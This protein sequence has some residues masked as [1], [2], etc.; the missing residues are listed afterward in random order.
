MTFP[1]WHRPYLALFEQTLASY[2][3]EVIGDV[4]QNDPALAQTLEEASKTWRLPYWDWCLYP[5]IPEEFSQPEIEIYSANGGTPQSAPNPL[6]QYKFRTRPSFEPYSN[7]ETTLRQ[8]S[9]DDSD[10]VS[11]T[12]KANANLAS[13]QAHL[14][15]LVME[16][17]PQP[18]DPI[19]P[20]F[21]FS[22]DQ[23]ELPV[24]SQQGNL[25]SLENIHNLIHGNVGGAGHFGQTWFAAFDP[26]FWV[27][28]CQVDR[29]FAVWEAAYPKI[30]FNDTGIMSISFRLT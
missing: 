13:D 2:F 22:N 10:A 15:T 8:P 26:I 14:K 19:T 29:L 7:W 11:Q 30:F 27:H 12:E 20:W 23:W 4:T 24:N 18:L 25:T 3:P 21:H 16:L 17:F 9:S 1:T 6:Q 28:H 5:Q